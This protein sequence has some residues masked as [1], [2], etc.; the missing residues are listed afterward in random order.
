MK[1]FV[2][3]PLPYQG[4]KSMKNML[5]NGL[6]YCYS[7]LLQSNKQ[8]DQS[9]EVTK[10]LLTFF[11]TFTPAR[12]FMDKYNFIQNVKQ[13]KHRNKSIPIDFNPFASDKEIFTTTSNDDTE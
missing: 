5:G 12:Y 8:Y 7:V 9:F 3:P 2:E 4:K 1:E 13:H 10:I 11:P 6:N